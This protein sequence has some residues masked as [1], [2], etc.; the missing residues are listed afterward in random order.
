VLH[1]L[2][3]TSSNF[4]E[5]ECRE[6]RTPG[7]RTVYVGASRRLARGGS[8]FALLDGTLVRFENV[9]VPERDVLA[10]FD[11]LEPIAADDIDFKGP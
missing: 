8:A 2:A 11:A 1:R 6:V 4:F 9:G 10:Y 3:A 7:G 5:G